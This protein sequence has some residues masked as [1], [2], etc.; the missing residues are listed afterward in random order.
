MAS[1]VADV[2]GG[3][4]D[5]VL[6]STIPAPENAAGTIGTV[7]ESGAIDLTSS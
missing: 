5:V 2:L 7:D 4:F 6:T 1:I 3:E